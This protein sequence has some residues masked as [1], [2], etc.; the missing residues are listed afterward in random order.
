MADS[1]LPAFAT[2]DEL[3]AWL[4]EPIAEEADV[5]RAELALR[6]ASVL[7]R[8]ATN[9]SWI[10][11]EVLPARLVDE[12]PEPVWTVTLLCAARAY[13]DPET[14]TYKRWS[15]RIDD[16]SL[17][18]SAAEVG[19]ALLPSEKAMLAA[20]VKTGLQ[21]TGIGIVSTTRGPIPPSSDDFAWLVNG[22]DVPPDSRG[23]I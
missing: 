22:P 9:R 15:D 16:G 13:G 5:K 1:S 7:V 17:D 14:L 4:G 3:S 20:V 21:R 10:Q 23:L 18:R 11:A 12:L 2:V 8:S 6:M 19:L